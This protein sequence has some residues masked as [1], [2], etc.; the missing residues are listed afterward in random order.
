MESL[1]AQERLTAIRHKLQGGKPAYL[2]GIGP[3]GHNAGCAL[4]EITQENGI[5]LICN[6]EEER[7]A[8]VKHYADYPQLSVKNVLLQLNRLG[9]RASDIDACLANWDYINL[10]SHSL[11]TFVEELPG[12]LQMLKPQPRE[13]F[14]T[15]YQVLLETLSA[16]RHLG[17]Q[18]G[19]P[20][21]F[22]IINLRHHDNHAYFSYLVSPFTEIDQPV[23]VVVMD[24]SGDDGSL[25]LYLVKD[26][27]LTLI[28]NNNAMFDSLGTFYT[29][30]SATQGGWTPL[31]SEGRYMGAAA[32]GD[33]NRS[34]NRFYRQLRQLIYFGDHGEIFLNRSLANWHRAGYAKPYTKRLAQLLGPP[35]LPAEMWNPDK[36]LKLEATTLQESDTTVQ[37]RFDKAAATQLV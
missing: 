28:R 23:M 3:G 26:E 6:N 1:Y 11:R 24:G 32:W 16:P 36:V 20:K 15:D 2:L 35:I 8:G 33:N 19:F 29:M 4:V 22:P 25:S 13:T 9:L 14:L 21:P 7:F 12:T 27:T 17:E 10:I 34:T 5:R 18:L 30:L 31:S 37:A